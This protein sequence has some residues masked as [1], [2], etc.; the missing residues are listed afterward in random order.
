MLLIQGF[1]REYVGMTHFTESI[2][3]E[4]TLAWLAVNQC[5][6][7]ESQHAHRA[8]A[9]KRPVCRAGQGTSRGSEADRRP[10]VVSSCWG[11]PG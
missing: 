8:C 10:D 11:K 4:P 9:V 5:H 6:A 3:E 1:P 2:V 7:A